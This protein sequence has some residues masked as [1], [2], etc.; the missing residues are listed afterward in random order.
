MASIRVSRVSSVLPQLLSKSRKCCW[1]AT[2][3]RPAAPV[4]A[5]WATRSSHHLGE[6]QLGR[7]ARIFR[8]FFLHRGAPGWLVSLRIATRLS[9]LGTCGDRFDLGRRKRFGAGNWFC[10][11][12]LQHSR[13][14]CV[15][16]R[17]DGRWVDCEHRGRSRIHVVEFERLGDSLTRLKRFLPA[18]RI[19]DPIPRL[20]LRV[21]LNPF[22][23]AR[24][25]MGWGDLRFQI[26]AVTVL[27][28]QVTFM[29]EL[30]ARTATRGPDAGPTTDRQ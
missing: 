6:L 5:T 21:V 18:L 25:S 16:A 2:T 30:D 3:K 24:Q 11:R 1:Y 27:E 12:P 23:P 10:G 4:T 9:L 22:A 14:R 7:A 8:D 28:S 29:N 19:V 20:T 17:G 13:W 15:R 26:Q